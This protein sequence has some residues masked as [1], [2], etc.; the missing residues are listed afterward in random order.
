MIISLAALTAAFIAPVAAADP[1]PAPTTGSITVHVLTTGSEQDDPANLSPGSGQQLDTPPANAPIAGVTYQVIRTDATGFAP[2]TQ[3]TGS[4]GIAAFT[5]LPLG[6]YQVSEIH[7]PRNVAP[8]QPFT[9][10]IP[11]DNGDG[12][13]NYDIHAYPKNDVN[14]PPVKTS[15]AGP[16]TSN[17]QAITYTIAAAIPYQLIPGPDG[18]PVTNPVSGL[19]V[20]DPLDDPNIDLA[21]SAAVIDS[22]T[23]AVTGGPSGPAGNPSFTADTDYTVSLDLDN[24][25]IEIDLTDA[26]L[27]KLTD[28][29]NGTSDV[30]VSFTVPLSSLATTASAVAGGGSDNPSTITNTAYV[31]RSAAAIADMGPGPYTSALLNSIYS[32]SNGVS[33]LCR[34]NTLVNPFGGVAIHKV[35]QN[36]AAITEAGPA[37]FA[38]YDSQAAASARDASHLVIPDDLTGTP[39]PS[40][41]QFQTLADTEIAPA[42]GLYMNT[43]QPDATTLATATPLGSV[44]GDVMFTG[45]Q[46]ARHYS[47]DNPASAAYGTTYWAVEISAPAGYELAA[48]PQ[49]LCVVGLLDGLTN[50][51]VTADD[52]E[53]DGVT[54]VM[55]DDDFAIVNVAYSSLI[56]LPFTGALA[57]WLLTIVGIG[58]IVGAFVVLARRRPQRKS[59]A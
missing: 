41:G 59:A 28:A 36:G 20:I 24:R 44:A 23:I 32:P 8:S 35:D 51:Q 43:S 27:A 34:S 25:I 21:D 13:W 30:A 46:C 2:Q 10:T 48:D 4:D 39:Y 31:A 55:T 17:S 56:S 9:V 54:P 37:T 5:G 57:Q 16:L 38:L 7:V 52:Y 53:N 40:N 49:P 12:T 18:T 33:V 45:G 15:S 14:D 50:G 19:R 11:M 26:G 22:V 6:S 1:S 29:A 3:T 58:L 47:A 42:L